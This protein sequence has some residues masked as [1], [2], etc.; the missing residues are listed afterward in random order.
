[1]NTEFRTPFEWFMY[2]YLQ[3]LDGRDLWHTL[4]KSKFLRDFWTKS[5]GVFAEM[6][7]IVYSFIIPDQIQIKSV[8]KAI[9]TESPIVFFFGQ[10]ACYPVITRNYLK[11]KFPQAFYVDLV[12]GGWF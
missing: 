1:M 9:G 10:T 4:Q 6:Q 12:N 8:L 7:I 11:D 5:G 2:I 3:N